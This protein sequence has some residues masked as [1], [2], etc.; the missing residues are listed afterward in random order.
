MKFNAG[1]KIYP[2]PSS[3]KM[4]SRSNHKNMDYGIILKILNDES[5]KV[6]CYLKDGS[7]IVYDVEAKYFSKGKRIN[8]F[9]I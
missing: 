2:L 8:R 7:E 5:I 3:N 9:E 4:Y 1:D 6:R